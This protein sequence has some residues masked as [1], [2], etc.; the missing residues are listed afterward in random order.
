MAN[1]IRVSICSVIAAMALMAGVGHLVG[2]SVSAIMMPPTSQAR[3]QFLTS[4]T[5]SGDRH[6]SFTSKSARS[7]VMNPTS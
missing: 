5:S 4:S 2:V 6:Q 3:T 7:D 1:E